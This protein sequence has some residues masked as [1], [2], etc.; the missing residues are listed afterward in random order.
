MKAVPQEGYAYGQAR[1]P[2]AQREFHITFGYKERESIKIRLEPLN[3]KVYVDY[4]NSDTQV[5]QFKELALED[6]I[7]L[8]K[9][10]ASP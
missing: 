6:F 8:I 4:V 10:A 5:W 2:Y 9:G 3:D 7:A 1:L